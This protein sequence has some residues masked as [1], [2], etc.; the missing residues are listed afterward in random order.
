MELTINNYPIHF[1][2][3]KE[4][5]VTDIIHSISQWAHERELIF[6]EVHIDDESYLIDRAPEKDLGDVSTINCI[7]QSKADLVFT[8][9]EEGASYCN[10][11]AAFIEQHTNADSLSK[12]Q[13]QQLITGIDWLL[14]VM[15]KVTGLLGISAEQLQV[16]DRT[17]SWYVEELETMHGKLEGNGSSDIAGV[18]KSGNFFTELR[19]V[20][21]LLLHSDEMRKLIIQSIDSPD[22]IISSLEQIRAEVADQ[23][24]KIEET[25]VAFQTGKDDEGSRGLQVFIDFMYRYTRTC[26]Q[27]GPVFN[28]DLSSIEVNGKSLEDKNTE[29]QDFLNETLSILENNDIISLSDILEYEIL[30][31][32]EDV[33]QYIDL[34]LAKVAGARE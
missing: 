32:L 20:F 15:S 24:K 28:I 31:A 18:L 12:E 16:K 33:E 30:P 23:L 19:A 21:R 25:A 14:E 34:V 10:R 13:V 17:V 6:T 29:L 7:I 3:E 11:V 8:I 5:T 4:K 22:I 27:V 2:I 26:Y 1:Q 9:I